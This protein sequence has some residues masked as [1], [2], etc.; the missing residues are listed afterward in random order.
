M[1]IVLDTDVILDVLLDREP[2]SEPAARLFSLAERGRLSG[3][4]CATSVTTV[5]YLASKVA[6]S[7]KAKRLVGRLLRI[8]AVAP[9]NGPVLKAALMGRFADF[10]DAV[11]SE[12]ANHVNAD[13]IVTHNVRDFRRAVRPVYTA[14]ELLKAFQGERDAGG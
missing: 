6:G 10:E 3:F 4:I 11:V 9:V 1:K 12:A 14:D 8:F 2:F 5:Y 13:G 7:A